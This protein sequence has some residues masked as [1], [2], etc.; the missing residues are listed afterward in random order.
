FSNSTF[1]TFCKTNDQAKD[2]NDVMKYIV[3]TI[4]GPREANY[5]S[6]SSIVFGNLEPLTDGT[7]AAPRPDIAL[8]AIPQQL[9]PTVR[10]ELQHHII[11]STSTHRL[12]APNFFMEAKGPDGSAAVILQQACYDGAVGT[13]AMH[14]LQ[15]YSREEL[16]YDRQAYTYSST[17]H[18]GQLKLFAYHATA[19]AAPGEQLQYYINQLRTFGITD[20]RETFVQGASA[21][22]NLRDLAMQQRNTFIEEANA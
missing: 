5:P 20:T 21:Y 15:N 22:R 12:I 13:R 18:D 3:P 8:G 6:T 17:Y 10:S 7:I 11:P 1:K 16:V 4:A 2:E 14:S 19:P 9:H